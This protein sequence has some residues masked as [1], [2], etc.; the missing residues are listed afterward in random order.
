[1]NNV[2]Y[3]YTFFGKVFPE[4]ADVNIP[5]WTA[6]LLDL[7]QKKIG[8]IKTFIGASQISIRITSSEKLENIGMNI[9]L[10][11]NFVEEWIRIQVDILGYTLGCGYDVEITQLIDPDG[12]TTVYGVNLEDVKA[13]EAKR[14]KK[15]L[16]IMNI[17]RDPTKRDY[18]RLCL[19]DLREAI[20]CPKD[21]GFFCYR[22][23]ESLKR[24][25][26]DTLNLENDE[27]KAWETF[28]ST[29]DIDRQKIEFIKQFADPVR[30]GGRKPFKAEE[31]KKIL[32]YTWEIVDKYIVF[33]YNG[34]KI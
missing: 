23:I 24:Y 34:Y 30:H 20:R 28:R 12:H 7:K 22:A 21:I 29:L 5:L 27:K 2:V 16:E 11:K 3:I 6:P 13:F 31:G 10:L 18:L 19:S 17:C 26:V 4:R 8:E 15:F 33:A 32:D 25:F 1:M 9:G 14:P